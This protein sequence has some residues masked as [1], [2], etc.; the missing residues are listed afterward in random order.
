M[1]RF[2]KWLIHKLGGICKDDF[3]KPIIVQE[4]KKDIVKLRT[5][6]TATK[7]SNLHTE[8]IKR[9]LIENLSKELCKFWFQIDTREEEYFYV[10]SLDFEFVRQ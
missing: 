6:F 5:E 8:E 4:D 10:Y 7:N 2:R 1:K 3:V 9:I